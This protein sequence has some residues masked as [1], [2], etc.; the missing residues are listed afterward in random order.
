MN[1]LSDMAQVFKY[2]LDKSS[3]KFK[4]P[5]CGKK[6][7]VRYIDIDRQYASD[8]FGRCDREVNCSYFV[9]PELSADAQVFERK[10]YEDPKPTSYI[11]PE[12]ALAS[13]NNYE[14]NNLYKY[15]VSISSESR[16]KD[17]IKKYRFGVDQSGPYTTDWTLFWQYDLHNR[18]RSAKM[19]KYDPTGHRCKESSAS[20]YHKKE[21]YFNGPLFP[22]FELGQCLFGEHLLP[23]C[24]KP[25]AVVESEKT[26][27]IASLFIDKYTWVACGG[28]QELRDA[29]V[30]VLKHRSV[31]LFPDLGGYDSWAIKAEDYGFN[32]SD[33]LE[34]IATDEDRK[35]GKDLADYIT[36]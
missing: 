25:I 19:I 33:H 28:L 12:Y 23:G 3:K 30:A 32:I 20:W 15:L 21:H 2:S 1:L 14:N 35:K 9:K 29:K 17:L 27:L 24:T 5:G 11:P 34:K 22:D 18:I 13:Y 31:T 4:C 26:A 36:Q 8:E 6:S 16:V 10:E 7:L